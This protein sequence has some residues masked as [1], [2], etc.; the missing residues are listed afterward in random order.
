MTVLK[1]SKA[2]V[3]RRLTIMVGKV[4]AKSFV[5]ALVE[6]NPHSRLGGQKLPCLLQRRD[7]HLARNG[8][9]TLKELFEGVPSF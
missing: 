3:S 1:S 6:K 2:S 8:R 4:L 7:G 5:H 9:I